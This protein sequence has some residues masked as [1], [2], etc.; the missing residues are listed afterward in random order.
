MIIMLSLLVFLTIGFDLISIRFIID[1]TMKLR[2]LRMLIQKKS[3][4]YK[5]RFHGFENQEYYL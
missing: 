3:I 4:N 2:S 1:L 5:E